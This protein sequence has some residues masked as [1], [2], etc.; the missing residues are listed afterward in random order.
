MQ[1]KQPAVDYV[2]TYE[3]GALTVLQESLTPYTVHAS[4]L[5]PLLYVRVDKEHEASLLETL[6]TIPDITYR[7]ALERHTMEETHDRL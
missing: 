4:S 7:R 3:R 1:M 2:I 5:E 6:A